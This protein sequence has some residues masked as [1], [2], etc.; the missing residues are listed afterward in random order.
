[1]S[2]FFFFLL[3]VA[4]LLVWAV[5]RRAGVVFTVTSGTFVRGKLVVALANVRFADGVRL[6][7]AGGSTSSISFYFRN[8]DVK[9]AILIPGTIQDQESLIKSLIDG[10]GLS[11]DDD[12][13]LEAHCPYCSRQLPTDAFRGDGTC[14]ECGKPL[15]PAIRKLNED[16]RRVYTGNRVGLVIVSILIATGLVVYFALAPTILGNVGPLLYVLLSIFI[17]L[18]L[19]Y[20]WSFAWR[21]FHRER[22]MLRL[23]DVLRRVLPALEPSSL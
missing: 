7:S 20:P 10:S 11:E 6:T 2:V 14:S 3:V 1:M 16:T 17:V 8:R 5:V 21:L 23:V 15:L 9:G 4:A 13:K 22:T 18:L 12:S 19:I